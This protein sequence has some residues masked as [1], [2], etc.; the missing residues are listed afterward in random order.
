MAPTAKDPPFVPDVAAPPFIVNHG[1]EEVAVQ[2][3]VPVPL[4]VTL[5]AWLEGL[6][7]P[8]IAENDKVAGFLRITA[9]DD[10]VGATVEVVGVS[11]WVNPGI[12]EDSF[13]MPRPLVDPAPDGEEPAAAMPEKDD[14]EGVD[15]VGLER[16]PASDRE[17]VVVVAEVLVGVTVFE[18]VPVRV[19][20]PL[21]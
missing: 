12:D 3:S 8:C 18:V 10:V 7:P 9:G 2:V 14:E 6:A 20:E 4:L 19:V 21:L 13:C 17:L 5:T 1:L 16:A 15:V 11:N